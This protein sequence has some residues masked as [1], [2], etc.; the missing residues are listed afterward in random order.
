MRSQLWL[1][2]EDELSFTM[3]GPKFR[4]LCGLKFAAKPFQTIVSW[5]SA[6][7]AFL[8]GLAQIAKEEGKDLELFL[9]KS[10][11]WETSGTDRLYENAFAGHTVHWVDRKDW[12]FISSLAA[13]EDALVI[14]EGGVGIHCLAG[15]LTLA[16]DICDQMT[17]LETEWETIWIDAGSGFTA[18]SLI[19]GLGLL[20]RDPPHVN[21]VLCA[22]NAESFAGGLQS[23]EAALKNAL[24]ISAIPAPY[25]CH[26][27]PTAA[28]YGA[29]NQAVWSTIARYHQSMGILL[30]PLYTAKLMMCFEAYPENEAGSLSTLIIHSGGGLNNFGYK[31]GLTVH[32]SPA[33]PS[34]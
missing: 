33:S 18:Q 28:S 7:S 21:V 8:L 4:K 30:D 17:R 12:P 34:E 32:H 2:R 9:L 15:A 26:R 16:L 1:K 6:R 22:G 20:L 11:P 29:T 23:L 19:L 25:S 24:N 31:S 13:R 14:P 10:T 27:P 3:S 5:G